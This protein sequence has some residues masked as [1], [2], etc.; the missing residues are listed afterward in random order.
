M[1]YSRPRAGG[2]IALNLMPDDELI[3]ARITDGTLNVFLGSAKGKSI[4]FHE[5]DV[6]PTGRVSRGVQ[7]H[8]P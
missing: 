5:S 2:I 7:R 6:R 3:A 1:A 8:A 4:R